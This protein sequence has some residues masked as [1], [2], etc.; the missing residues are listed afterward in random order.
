MW[1]SEEKSGVRTEVANSVERR[2]WEETVA[3]G[4]SSQ[5]GVCEGREAGCRGRQRGCAYIMF[6]SVMRRTVRLT[7]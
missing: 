3:P 4:A 5:T 2:L 7:Y 6:C 1:G